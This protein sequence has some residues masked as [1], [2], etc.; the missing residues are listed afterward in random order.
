MCPFTRKYD[1]R[2]E[3]IARLRREDAE[4]ILSRWRLGEEQ[5]KRAEVL[6]RD[7]CRRGDEAI[8]DFYQEFYGIP[9]DTPIEILDYEVRDAFK[10]VPGELR[11]SLE[12]IADRIRRFNQKI[13]EGL[14]DTWIYRVEPGVY[15]GQIVRPVEKVGA[16]IPG[17]LYPYPSTA[18]MTIVPGRVAGCRNIFAASPPRGRGDPGI[19]PS[20]IVASVIAGADKIYRLGGVQAAAAM[21]CGTET[22][23]RVDKIVGPG[24][25]WFTAG[26][27]LAST[28]TGI[29]MLAGPSEIMVLSDGSGDPG[30]IALDLLA[31]AEHGVLSSSIL[32]T[33][34]E[35]QAYR[36]RDEI[37][38]WL[39]K[40]PDKARETAAESMSLYGGILVADGLDEAIWFANQYA[41]EH[42]EVITRPENTSI[43]L[44]KISSAGTVFIGEYSGAALG[45]YS[46][47]SNHVLPT[48]GAARSRGG[49]SVLDYIKII[50]IQYVEPR[51]L[52][53][54]GRDASVLAGIEGFF[55]HKKSIDARLERLTGR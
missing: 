30:L 46:L 34:S 26:K 24:G 12:R 23:E 55:F 28:R 18:L 53:I 9:R 41:P 40:A 29:D 11:G 47:G 37:I 22:V 39:D 49:L 14:R 7:V 35:E 51:G 5:V 44:E 50:D 21:A 43:V 45:D 32:V 52:E 15:V 3:R 16:Y 17:G 33:T 48:G 13:L 42:L 54:T 2:L 6:F 36:V 20:I 38:S 19:D 1:I 8:R 25:P 31:Q 4:K 27:F 10:K